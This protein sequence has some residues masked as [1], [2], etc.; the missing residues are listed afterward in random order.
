MKS[1]Q[2]IFVHFIDSG[3]IVHHVAR[4][5]STNALDSAMIWLR[6]KYL[7]YVDVLLSHLHSD[8]PALQVSPFCSAALGD[9][10]Y[11]SAL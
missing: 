10:S 7:S 1:L 6:K 5:A 3:D 11:L 2:R 8:E 9:A 4:S